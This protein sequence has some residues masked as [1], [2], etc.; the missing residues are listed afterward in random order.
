MTTTGGP[1]SRAVI[2]SCPAAV[3]PASGRTCR[4]LSRNT[5]RW[6][7]V[8]YGID[9]PRSNGFGGHEIDTQFEFKY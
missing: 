8:G 9:A 4:S 7:W 1:A 6:P 2:S 5:S 3:S